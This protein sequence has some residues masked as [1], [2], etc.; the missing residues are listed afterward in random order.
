M[1]KRILGIA[2]ALTAMF[3]VAV[4]AQT[5]CGKADCQNAC[6]QQTAC[7]KDGACD[8]VCNPY[9]AVFAGLNLT[10]DQQTRLKAI[11]DGRRQACKANRNDARKQKREARSQE[12]RNYL[13][14]VKSVLT[15]D[16]YVVFLENFVVEG[17]AA[18]PA[19]GVRPGRISGN[20][21]K[22]HAGKA[23]RANCQGRTTCPNTQAA[24]A[25]GK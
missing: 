13:N 9:Q 4:S 5:P 12:R 11:N 19:Q 14:Q 10:A 23:R 3:G 21:H 20:H 24:P 18:R 2:V 8:S 22:G 1:K 16:Q 25:Q 7:T 17:P 15:P 6:P